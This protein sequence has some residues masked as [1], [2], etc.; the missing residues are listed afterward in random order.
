MGGG[1]PKISFVGGSTL[2]ASLEEDKLSRPPL[3]FPS[4][5]GWGDGS[6]ES[7][8]RD[9]RRSVKCIIRTFR[10]SIPRRLGAVYDT[11]RNMHTFTKA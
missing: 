7:T 2:G 1:F 10:K 4:L 8:N 5:G 6:A 3:R 11:L 9:H